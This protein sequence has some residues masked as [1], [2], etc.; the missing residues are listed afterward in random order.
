MEPLPDMR[1]QKAFTLIEVLVVVA[2]IALLVAI[3]LPSLAA[4]RAQARAVLCMNN[5][6]QIGLAAQM[7]A[8]E[9]KDTFP[10]SAHGGTPD[11]KTWWLHIL[12]RYS[13]APLLFQCPDDEAKNF[14]DWSKP[15]PPKSELSKYRWASYAVN[16]LVVTHTDAD[17]NPITAYSD[18]ISR[19]RRP[20]DVVLVGESEDSL[21][22]VDHIHPERF[23]W[24]GGPEGQIATKRHQGKANYLFVDAHVARLRIEAGQSH[25]NSL[26]QDLKQKFRI[27]GGLEPFALGSHFA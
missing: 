15:L 26:A 20:G 5:V 27:Y 23:E 18:K 25:L 1:F 2:I 21:L 24:T 16:Y 6:K 10:S 14:L 4:A 19:V 12:T 3:L 11:P 9:F 8:M 13:K 17:N 22:G 7:Y